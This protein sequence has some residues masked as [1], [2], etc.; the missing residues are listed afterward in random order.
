MSKTRA[1]RPIHKP[2][3][4][5]FD[6]EIR[7]SKSRLGHESSQDEPPDWEEIAQGL[8]RK[9]E[10]IQTWFANLPFDQLPDHSI[11]LAGERLLELETILKS[12]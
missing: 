1:S 6:L 3:P 7:P 12:D 8:G 11:I 2:D 10:A 9:L 4:H 5:A